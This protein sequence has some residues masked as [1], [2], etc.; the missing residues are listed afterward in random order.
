MKEDEGPQVLFEGVGITAD[1]GFAAAWKS[2]LIGL[3]LTDHRGATSGWNRGYEIVAGAPSTADPGAWLERIHPDD[4]DE[5]LRQ[6]TATVRGGPEFA[7]RYR[8]VRPHGDTRWVHAVTLPVVRDGRTRALIGAVFDITDDIENATTV[9]QERSAELEQLIHII[10]HDL[11]SPLRAV[12]SFA[13]LLERNHAGE[14]SHEA[15]GFIEEIVTG[16]AR[17]RELL[18]DL[19]SYLQTL[20][21]DDE[22]EEVDLNA[23][24]AECLGLVQQAATAC[25]A[26]IEVADLPTVVGVPPLLRAVFTNMLTNALTYHQPGAS[27]HIWLTSKPVGNRHQISF[28]DDGIGIPAHEH[29]RIMRPFVRLH[30]VEDYPGTGMGLAI[31]HRALRRHGTALT[32]S[33][34][35][36]GSGTT[37]SFELRHPPNHSQSLDRSF[38]L[39]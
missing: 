13:Q 19:Q 16:T 26:T 29:D 35:K 39:E 5:L 17:M 21:S 18:T 8:I 23:I 7:A 4:R 3:A 20:R 9:V 2:E 22:P 33:D 11:S 31:V 6:G 25:G 37:L 10:A 34:R 1:E 12:S 36:S 32:I 24:V 30:G 38:A 14:L 15:Q 27:P 28:S